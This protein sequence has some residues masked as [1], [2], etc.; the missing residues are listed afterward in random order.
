MQRVGV[1]IFMVSMGLGL[2]AQFSVTPTDSLTA[3]VNV[4]A[5]YSI[6]KIDIIN[7]SDGQSGFNVKVDR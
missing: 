1:S 5:I 6:H 4:D 7:E 2:N 3:T